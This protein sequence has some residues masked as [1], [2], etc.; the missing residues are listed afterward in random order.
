MK[1]E[2]RLEKD[3]KATIYEQFRQNFYAGEWGEAIANV[4]EI[5]KKKMEQPP[6]DWKTQEVKTLSLK[7]KVPRWTMLNMWDMF[8]QVDEDGSGQIEFDEFHK[9]MTGAEKKPGG[10]TKIYRDPDLDLGKVSD[11]MVSSTR[12]R[13]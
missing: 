10:K 2:Q 7:M 9:I 8:E 6:L 4:R 11:Q 12:L 3:K 5:S 13:L 1:E